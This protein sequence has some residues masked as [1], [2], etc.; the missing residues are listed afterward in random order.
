MNFRFYKLGFLKENMREMQK[1]IEIRL[2]K[3]T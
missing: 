2:I 1:L 3:I